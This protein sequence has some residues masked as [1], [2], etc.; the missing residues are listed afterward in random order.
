[1]AADR[2]PDRQVRG[3]WISAASAERNLG[4]LR[5]H[6]L[7]MLRQVGSVRYATAG[8]VVVASG[9]QVSSV[10]VVSN[11]E[12]ELRA[13]LDEGRATMAVVR[14]GGIIADIPM[15]LNAPMPF[16]AIAS[17]DTECI[18]LSRQRWTELLRSSPDLA[19]RWMTSIARRLDDDRRRLVVVTSKPL[20][21][22]VAFLLLDLAED[23]AGRE[24]VVKLSHT[25]LA[26]LLGARRQ[27]V[28][29]VIGELKRRSLIE[30]RYGQTV[31]RDVHGLR[32]VMGSAP[33][34]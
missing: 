13:R 19:M 12:L 28:T 22:Q 33:L 14:T 18:T 7:R 34:P 17:R 15:L 29:R 25:T 9:S 3:R 2:T 30:S 27:S 26:H 1:V 20:I 10:H 23:G 5:P 8:T 11:G 16:D 6:E 32:E 21:G 31:L 24:P 4:L